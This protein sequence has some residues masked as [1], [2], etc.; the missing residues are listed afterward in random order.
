MKFPAS[1]IKFEYQAPVGSVVVWTDSDFAG[2]KESRKS[3]GGG[4][5]VMGNHLIRSWSLTQSIIALS[6]GE[7]EYYSLVKGC[8]NG[9]GLKAMNMELGVDM[10]L[11]I[12]TDASAAIG[13]AKR[14]GFGKIRHIDVSQLWIQEMI[15]RGKIKVRKV[16]LKLA[17]VMH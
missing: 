2:C 9:L 3:T 14:T 6:S 10:E 13:I 11:Q 1:V 7:A 4:A 8:S 16:S 15:S 12:N 17:C 5:M